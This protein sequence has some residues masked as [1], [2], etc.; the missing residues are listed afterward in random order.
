VAQFHSSSTCVYTVAYLP[1]YG[2]DVITD[3]NPDQDQLVISTYWFNTIQRNM[4][5]RP[6]KAGRSFAIAPNLAA[7]QRRSA[8]IVYV[9][10]NGG[11]YYNQNRSNPGFGQGGL[12][13]DLQDGLQLSTRNIVVDYTLDQPIY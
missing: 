8:M 6:E 9:S 13:A 1:E 11:L 3:F 12:I 5:G 7:A 4:Y 2:Y 10:K